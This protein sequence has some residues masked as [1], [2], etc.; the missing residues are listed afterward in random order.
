MNITRLYIPLAIIVT[1]IF[2]SSAFVGIRY[3]DRMF[4]PGALA[5]LRFISASLFMLLFFVVTLKQ[6]LTTQRQKVRPSIGIYLSLVL[7]G[8]IGLGIYAVALNAGEQHVGAGVASFITSQSPI[9]TTILAIIF[10]KERINIIGVLGLAVS[11]AGVILIAVENITSVQVGWSILAVVLSAFCTAVYLNYQ[12]IIKPY[13]TPFFITAISIW[14]STVFLAIF[15]IPALIHDLHSAPIIATLVVIYLGVFSTAVAFLTF[16]YA[17]SHMAA[18][19]LSSFLYCLPILVI[20]QS[21]FWLGEG[22]DFW[23]FIGGIIALS[24]T[25]ILANASRIKQRLISHPTH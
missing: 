11:T 6:R 23:E 17:L 16:N 3:T 25:F 18:T 7:F 20:L 1:L 19:K 4:D 14:A 9:L 10:L 12:R 22:I 15:Y 21:W 5:L 8:I 13:F 2:W 24:G